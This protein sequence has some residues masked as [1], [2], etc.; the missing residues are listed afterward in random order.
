MLLCVSHYILKYSNFFYIAVSKKFT[1]F[2]FKCLK[3]I[4]KNYQIIQFNFIFEFFLIHDIDKKH[5]NV[6]NQTPKLLYLCAEI[7]NDNRFFCRPWISLK[8]KTKTNQ[9]L[10]SYLVSPEITQ[11]IV[12]SPFKFVTKYD[13]KGR[14]LIQPLIQILDNPTSTAIV[15]CT[16]APFM[17]TKKLS[18]IYSESQIYE[19]IARVHEMSS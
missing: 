15:L 14:I 6:S 16:Q 12:N 19:Y 3:C 8:S 5:Q 13:K 2:V 17:Y 4:Y 1:F 11:T 10:M 18:F 7:L 9:Q